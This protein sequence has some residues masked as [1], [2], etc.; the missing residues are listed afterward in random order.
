MREGQAGV[1]DHQHE[2]GMKVADEIFFVNAV[3]IGKGV[4]VEEDVNGKRPA[5]HTGVGVP[6]ER[7]L[8][9]HIE[10]SRSLERRA[11]CAEDRSPPV[12]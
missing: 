4:A 11:G 3:A 2:P 10:K 9:C 8:F 7:I 5:L 1:I 6:T 12:N